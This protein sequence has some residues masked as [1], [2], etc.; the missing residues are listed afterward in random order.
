MRE[1][2]EHLK[3]VM[4]IKKTK[5]EKSREAKMVM[6]TWSAIG[7]ITVILWVLTYNLIF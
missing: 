7:I 2:N 5:E 4:G 3:H 1:I 6:I